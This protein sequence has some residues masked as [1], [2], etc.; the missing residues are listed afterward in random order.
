MAGVKPSGALDE[1]EFERLYE[2]TAPAIKA[3]ILHHCSDHDSA[4]DLCQ[5][6][7]VRFIEIQRKKPKSVRKPRAYLYRIASSV[8]A[9]HGRRIQR[10]RRFAARLKGSRVHLDPERHAD[11]IAVRDA[12]QALSDRERK[13]LWLI[14]AEGFRHREISR[15]MRIG[16]ASVR[17]LAFRARRKLLRRLNGVTRVRHGGSR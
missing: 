4:D 7:F 9:D 3:F 16:A 10:D 2:E 5:A 15:I 12:L 11:R 1:Q 13:L 6:T 8:I 14:Y 17:V